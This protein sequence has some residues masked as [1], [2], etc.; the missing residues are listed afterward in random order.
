MPRFP[1]IV[2]VGLLLFAAAVQWN[3]P[4]PGRWIAV[5]AGAAA[6]TP[7]VA[8]GR[9]SPWTAL[10]AGGAL[11]GTGLAWVARVLGEALP[12]TGELARESSGLLLA[13][14]WL[15]WVAA[16]RWRANERGMP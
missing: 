1:L 14:G 5:Y 11:C 4:D 16:R 3:D 12:A 8:A 7:L 13:G 2:A 9:L 10:A 6:L 15:V